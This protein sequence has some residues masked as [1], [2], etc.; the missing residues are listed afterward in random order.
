ME[1]YIN[2]YENIYGD[3]GHKFLDYCGND[4]KICDPFKII[5]KRRS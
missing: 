5:L 2:C 1:G 3:N 4:F